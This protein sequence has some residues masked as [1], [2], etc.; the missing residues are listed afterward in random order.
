MGG[1][2]WEF[3]SK[4]IPFFQYVK[5][6]PSDYKIN[7]GH[8]FPEIINVNTAEEI[9]KHLLKFEQNPEFYKELGKN[10]QN[11]FNKYGGLG[12]AKKYK[13]LIEELYLQKY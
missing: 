12:L 3:M 10:L 8:P 2:G 1:T 7:T 4:G 5:Q 11:W 13:N 9:Q 6:S